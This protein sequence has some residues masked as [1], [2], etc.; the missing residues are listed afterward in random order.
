MAGTRTA[1]GPTTV[2]AVDT[3]G[4]GFGCP[5]ATFDGDHDA[6]GGGGFFGHG[7]WA[8]DPDCGYDLHVRGP[9][10]AVGDFAFNVTFSVGEDDQD[11]PRKVPV[12]GGVACVTD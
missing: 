9:H 11:G 10:V 12:G 7:A 8:E 3:N 4:V 2:S 1:T 5:G 6:G